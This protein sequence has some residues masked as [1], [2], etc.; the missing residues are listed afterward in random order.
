VCKVLL[1]ACVHL[2]LLSAA[3]T[4]ISQWCLVLNAMQGESAMASLA[5]AR[6]TTQTTTVPLCMTQMASTWRLCATCHHQCFLAMRLEHACAGLLQHAAQA[7]MLMHSCTSV[8]HSIPWCCDGMAS[9]CN[10]LVT[11]NCLVFLIMQ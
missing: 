9:N 3:Y 8:C 6:S 10:T 2:T 7:E 11:F 5:C 1:C 4:T